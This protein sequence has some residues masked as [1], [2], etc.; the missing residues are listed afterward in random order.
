MSLY[1][2]EVIQKTD[3]KSL[4]VTD[5]GLKFCLYNK[6]IK[7]F[8]IREGCTVDDIAFQ[9]INRILSHRALKYCVK[10]LEGKDYSIFCLKNRLKFKYY[11][12]EAIEFA[13]N[14]LI[15]AGYLD[16]ESFARNYYE[17]KKQSFGV[18]R[19]K[20]ELMKNGIS[21]NI[22]DDVL[23]N[24]EDFIDTMALIKK[25]AISKNFDLETADMKEKNR[26]YRFLV[27]KGIDFDSINSYFSL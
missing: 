23:S 15:E 8:N 9:K 1:I 13:V 12:D 21:E 24:E 16:D 10:L 5:C 26:F 20:N 11:T 27:R 19:I 3:K 4:I 18:R 17:L 7:D 14:K 2:S 22:I 25:Y 6:E